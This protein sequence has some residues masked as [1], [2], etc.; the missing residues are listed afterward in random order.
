MIETSLNRKCQSILHATNV[1]EFSKGIVE[2][3][4]DRGFE[5]M[6]VAVII[7]HSPTLTEFKTVTNAPPAFLGD[8]ENLDAGLIDPVSQHC[9]RSTMPILWDRH[10]YVDSKE[11]LLWERQAEH[12]YRSGFAF[13]MHF[14]KGMHFMFGVD[15]DS[16]SC[17][18][19]SNYKSSL[20]EILLFGAHAQASAFE[21]CIPTH[22]LPGNAWE[23]SK[24]E[25]DTLRWSMDGKSPWEIGKA[26]AISERHAL[27]F[28]QRAMQKLECTSKYQTVLRAIKLGLIECPDA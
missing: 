13:A 7:D 20:E 8:F 2:F 15:C 24:S 22:P 1:K 18:K 26:M 3:V 12:G 23:L 19:L 17:E 10:T 4:Q 5:W 27:L 6:A 9:K 25:I 11:R 16:D 28:I 21:L 14:D